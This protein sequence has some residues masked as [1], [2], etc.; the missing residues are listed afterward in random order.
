[1]ELF[2]HAES[3]PVIYKELQTNEAGLR[4]DDAVRRLKEDGPNTLP[5]TK[6]DGYLIIFL[7]QFQS[8][9]I[10][11]LF[12][13]SVAVFLLGEVADGSIILAVLL[14]NAVVGTI[15]E[16]KAQNTLRAL[17]RYVETMATVMRDGTEISIPDYEVVRGDILVLREG[18]KVSSDAR[19]ILSNGLKLDEASLTGES[20][21]VGKTAEVMIH[22]E[23]LPAAEQKNMV[24]KG[25][26]I[27][28]GNG[29]A[30]VVKTGV[31]TAIGT[32]AKEISV[33]D[34]EIPLKANIRYLSRAIIAV[35]GIISVL[36]FILGLLKGEKIITIFATVISLAVSVIP[37]GL[38]I[39]I[40]LVLATGVWR[41]SKRNALVKKLQAVEALGQARIIAVDKT[42][43]IT[44]NELVVREIWTEGKTFS[45]GG[46]G[47]EPEG[48]VS[49]GGSVVDAANHP[50]LLLIGKM[51]ALSASARVFFSE[52]EKRWRVIGD[53]TEAAIRVFGEKVGFKRGDMLHESPLVSEIPF[54]YRLKYHAAVS[55]AEG[56]NFLIVSGAPETLLALSTHIRHNGH[57][58]LIERA[59]RKKIEDMLVE[60]SNRGLRVVAIA[61]REEFSEVLASETIQNLVFV[62][63]FGMQDILRPEVAEA[64]ARATAAGIRVVMITGDYTPTAR[65]IAK[66]AG[67][68]QEGDELLTGAEI[69]EMS[70]DELN[71]RVANVSVYARVTPEHKLRIINAYKKRGEIV[72]MTGDGVN[73]AP[74]L[75][76]ADLGV[77]MGKIGTEVAKEAADIVLLDDNFGS[78]VSAVEEGR[79]IYKT[80]KKVILYL[81]STSLGE[82]LTITGALIIGYPL[83]L[84]AAQI[85]WLNFVTDGFLD[86][87][88]AMEPKESGL[89][90][91]TFERPKKYLVDGL[92]ARRMIFMALP[93]MFGTLFLFQKYFETDIGKAW[94]VSL[95]A[96]AVFQWFNA[97]N[98]RSESKSFFQ[99]NFFSNKYLIG[100]TAITISFQMLAVY[101]PFFQQFLRTV[102]L[103]LS[104]WVMIIVV[105]TSII[106]V[107]EIRKFFYRKRRTAF[108]IL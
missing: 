68:W 13:A 102:P 49:F 34:T 80:I 90:S 101:T 100:A 88:L 33:I 38:P 57:N 71:V 47:Y 105:A 95:T 60:M 69:D 66:E 48:I 53:P 23:N 61:M 10:Y 91:G 107:E 29:Q 22:K 25:T 19:I 12:A 56:S 7:R 43:T 89:L 75:A 40:T 106:L 96:L 31:Y 92:M 17:K 82:V 99:M 58:E 14:F 94:T 84:L 15:Q 42:G 73:D 83:P 4:A 36:L 104:E 86:V 27:V 77:A 108:A 59:D 32:I 9:L 6:P 1:M 72:A 52:V 76:A 30:V 78:I 37:E 54:D 18:E 41:M 64:M 35:V 81:F 63:F 21:P 67:I 50:E 46:I 93:M 8:P 87:A 5:E 98:C 65:A 79:S 62:G 74:S 28:I 11:L 24:F 2:W 55:G 85:I 44:K 103:N 16:G 26:N 20:E 39:V 51:A 70:D 45:I 3:L 97:W